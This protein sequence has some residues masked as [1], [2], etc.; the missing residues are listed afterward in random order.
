MSRY[1][2][3]KEMCRRVGLARWYGTKLMANAII[4]ESRTGKHVQPEMLAHAVKYMSDNRQYL[5]PAP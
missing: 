2:L 4:F 3:V 1:D 5:V